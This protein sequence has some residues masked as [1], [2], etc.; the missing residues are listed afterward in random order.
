[1]KRYFI[2]IICLIFAFNAFCQTV[3]E[4]KAVDAYELINS[5]DTDSSIMLDG[6]SAEMFAEKHI[7]GAVNID[8]F[9][10]TLS[11]ELEKYLDVNEL[12]VYCTNSRRAELIIENLQEMHYSG[13][14]IFISDGIN[15]W[16]LAGYET[17]KI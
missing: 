14:I 9:Q 4:I 10:E 8:A 16:I 5:R 2:I 7:E 13:K 6:R 15:G 17:I 12:I 1:M 3:E 11:S